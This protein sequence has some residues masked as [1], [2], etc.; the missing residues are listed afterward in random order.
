MKKIFFL[1]LFMIPFIGMTQGLDLTQ[2]SVDLRDNS[3]LQF[4]GNPVKMRAI[5][6][7]FKP[8]VSGQKDFFICLTI[9]YY[10]S[11]AGAY[12]NPI[13]QTIAADGTLSS[14]EK[15]ELLAIYGDRRIEYSTSGKWVDVSGNIVTSSTPGAI[16]EIQYWQGFKLNQVTGIGTLANQGALDSEYL[17]IKQIVN[18]MN[19]RKNW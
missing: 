1:L 9:Q 18:K 17:T 19:S 10:E 11:V 13:V 8:I 6:N 4:N 16:Q 7:D 15:T 3:R 2:I 12:G 14:D 5:I